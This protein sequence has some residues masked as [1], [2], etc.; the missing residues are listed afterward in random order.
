MEKEMQ[1]M[2]ICDRVEAVAGVPI[3]L[4]A[5]PGAWLNSNPDTRGIARLSMTVVDGSLSEQVF[6]IGP[7]GLIDWGEIGASVFTS[8]TV[9]RV[10]AGFTC[11]CDFGFAASQLHE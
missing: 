1:F 7:D 10:G 3:D 11:R 8:S 4:S 6:G 9:S 2:Q 5:F